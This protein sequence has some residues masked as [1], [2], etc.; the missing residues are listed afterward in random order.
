M[1]TVSPALV[2]SMAGSTGLERPYQACGWRQDKAEITA[3]KD[4]EQPPQFN[5]PVGCH[6][7]VREYVPHVDVVGQT[8]SASPSSGGRC[9][10]QSVEPGSN[11]GSQGARAAGWP[12]SSVTVHVSRD[13]HHFWAPWWLEVSAIYN[14]GRVRFMIARPGCTSIMVWPPLRQGF[15]A[16]AL[17]AV[18]SYS[19]PCPRLPGRVNEPS[20]STWIP[21]DKN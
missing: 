14:R 7:L 13:N 11:Q 4:A 16:R 5:R 1:T 8:P 12:A 6:L 2:P 15:R 17:A 9:D 10:L 21:E 3:S 18:S 19:G 20:T